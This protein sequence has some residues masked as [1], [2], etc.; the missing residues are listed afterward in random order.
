MTVINRKFYLY[1]ALLIPILMIVIVT[2]SVIFFKPPA[3]T[4]QYNF[5]YVI[6]KGYNPWRC[7]EQ[8]KAQ[9]FPGTRNFASHPINQCEQAKFFIYH[10]DRN[11]SS[12]I[13]ADKLKNL[14]FISPFQSP[15]GFYISVNCQS[16]LMPP[17]YPDTRWINDVCLIKGN[18]RKR[19]I[20]QFQVKDELYSFAFIGWLKNK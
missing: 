2:I 11:Q 20:I 16:V 8:I 19:L 7:Q 1:A 15:D 4:P 18:F 13:D 12:P 10:V 5:V 17:F 6:V 9:L 3:P 14:A